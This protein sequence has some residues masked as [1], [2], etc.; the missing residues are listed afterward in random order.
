MESYEA[1][2]ALIEHIEGDVSRQELRYKM[3]RHTDLIEVEVDAAIEEAEALGLIT[4]SYWGITTKGRQHLLRGQNLLR[5]TRA[6]LVGQDGNT[7]DVAVP[8]TLH[9][10]V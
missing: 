10:A 2:A 8:A 3:L 9:A 4:K 7:K 6:G 5:S 1:V